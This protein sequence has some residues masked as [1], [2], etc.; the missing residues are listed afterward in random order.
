MIITWQLIVCVL[1]AGVCILGL[2]FCLWMAAFDR[3]ECFK[4]KYEF[5][6]DGT[7]CTVCGKKKKDSEHL[8]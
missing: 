7:Y 6:I 3:V 2:C 4:H 8:T 1:G 5:N